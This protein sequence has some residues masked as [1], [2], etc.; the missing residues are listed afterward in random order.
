MATSSS[1][2]L[3][4]LVQVF[5]ETIKEN[6]ED[7][8]SNAI[9]TMLAVNNGQLP[10][11]VMIESWKVLR[12]LKGRGVPVPYI[13]ITGDEDEGMALKFQWSEKIF[14]PNLESSTKFVDLIIDVN[15]FQ[16]IKSFTNKR[17][18]WDQVFD[19]NS[20]EKTC[21]TLFSFLEDLKH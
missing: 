8:I 7:F 15:F 10:E 3:L 6:E 17:E 16:I 21:E 9:D 1:D 5:F 14:H 18:I 19:L 13:Y 11:C 4:N 2:V 12:N 20:L